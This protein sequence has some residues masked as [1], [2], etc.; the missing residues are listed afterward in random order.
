MVAGECR[1]AKT[2]GYRISRDV[3]FAYPVPPV[4]LVSS[5]CIHVVHFLAAAMSDE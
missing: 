5:A 1:H 4:T 2:S 3:G